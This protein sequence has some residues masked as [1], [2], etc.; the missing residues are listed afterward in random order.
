MSEVEVT[1]LQINLTRQFK[2]ACLGLVCDQREQCI[3]NLWKLRALHYF[4]IQFF[5]PQNHLPTAGRLEV[6]T[7]TMSSSSL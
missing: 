2:P 3:E 7:L 5:V 6:T 1:L 4:S